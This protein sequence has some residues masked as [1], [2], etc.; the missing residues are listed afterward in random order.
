MLQLSDDEVL[1]DIARSRNR[2]RASYDVPG[3][4][5]AICGVGYDVREL[6]VNRHMKKSE[7]ERILHGEVASS[8]SAAS[9]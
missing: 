5:L 2:S 3:L 6:A 7:K 8:F 4:G 9:S 1:V